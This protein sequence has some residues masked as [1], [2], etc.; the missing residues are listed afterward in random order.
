MIT[1]FILVSD[2]HYIDNIRPDKKNNISSI[3]SCVT[4]ENI[5]ALIVP[6]DLTDIGSDGNCSIWKKG[7]CCEIKKETNQLGN[8]KTQFINT[9]EPYV[10][11]YLSHGNHDTYRVSMISDFKHCL[12]LT[13]Y[14]NPV[15]SYIESRH[16]DTIY[17]FSKNNIKFISLGMYPDKKGIE[18][19]KKNLLSYISTI[20]FFHFDF[21]SVKDDGSPWWNKEDKQLFYDTIRD[22]NILC[23]CIGHAH[24]TYSNR[25]WPSV[26]DTIDITKTSTESTSSNFRVLNAAGV[27][28]LKCIYTNNGLH[29]EEL[30]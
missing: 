29:V 5:D 12:G 9:L 11:I 18:Y 21:D 10:D 19:L 25:Y 23:I 3:L 20:I 22:Y 16:G 13:R 1:K 28:A 14:K 30:I 8:L 2:L 26:T 4:S 7:N 24:I 27:S 6:G 15:L 17:S